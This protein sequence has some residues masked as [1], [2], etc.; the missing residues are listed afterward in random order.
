MVLRDEFDLDVRSQPLPALDGPLHGLAARPGGVVGRVLELYGS[1]FGLGL[2]HDLNFA[3]DDL[4]NDLLDCH[5]F[6]NDLLHDPL[7]RHFLLDDPFDRHF[8]LND[9][10]D[11]HNLRFTTGGESGE[12]GYA[13]DAHDGIAQHAPSRNDWIHHR[14]PHPP[15]LRLGNVRSHFSRLTGGRSRG[16]RW[17]SRRLSNAELPYHRLF[18]HQFSEREPQRLACQRPDAP[19]RRRSGSEYTRHHA[20]LRPGIGRRGR[21]AR[22][23]AAPTGWDRLD[24]GPAGL[25]PTACRVGRWI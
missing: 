7:D 9:L 20:G 3:G 1:L 17:A 10:L 12:P 4:L 19:P 14:P 24:P 5:L 16:L 13:G 23:K 25:A 15:A 8:L 6:L 18:G 22:G 2:H 21:G 11:G